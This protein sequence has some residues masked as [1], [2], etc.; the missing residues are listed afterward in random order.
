M[1]RLI[2]LLL[3]AIM[4][5]VVAFAD[6]T[7]CQHDFMSMRN[8]TSH[9][10]ECQKCYEIRN[11]GNH[12]FKDGVCTVCGYEDTEV[13]GEGGHEHIL[14]NGADM[15]YHFEECQV[16][17]ERFNVKDHTFKDDKCTVCGY[18][19]F[20]NPFIDVSENAWF[21]NDVIRAYYDGLINGKTNTTFAP[22][23]N[24]TYV[25]AI[26]LAA[27][28]HQKYT[29][30][31]VTL[32]VGNPWYKP[33]LD[34][35]I[36]NGILKE[37]HGY[38]LNAPATRQGYMRIFAYSLPPEALE[39]I[40]Y[41]A[42]D[43]IPDVKKDPAIYKLYRAGIVGGV[44]AA[45]N[46]NPTANIKRSE[47]AAV[48]TRMMYKAARIEFTLGEKPAETEPLRFKGATSY[49][50][51]GT[52]KFVASVSGGEAPYTYTWYYSDG[53]KGTKLISDSFVTLT[54]DGVGGATAAFIFTENNPYLGKEVKLEVT[55]ANGEKI[56][57]GYTDIPAYFDVEGPAEEEPAETYEKLTITEQPEYIA[58]AKDGDYLTYSVFVKGGKQP[59]KF[60]WLYYTGYK[61]LTDTFKN[62][63][64]AMLSGDV[65]TLKFD[66][67]SPY[68]EKRFFCRV[69]DENGESVSSNVI[70]MPEAPFAME[71]EDIVKNSLG[72]IVVG[73]V[74][75]GKIVPGEH[76]VF[77][78]DDKYTY[79]SG[80]VEAIEMF[81]K[82]L[83]MATAGDRVGLLFKE[84][85]TINTRAA[86]LDYDTQNLIGDK[87]N[88][89]IKEALSVSVSYTPRGNI[90]EW[91]KMS[92]YATG[93]MEPYTYVWQALKDGKSAYNLTSIAKSEEWANG[94]DK[95]T[96]NILLTEQQYAF[97]MSFR[98]MITDA[99]GNIAYSDA[100]IPTPHDLVIANHPQ[101][102]Y[103]NYG[104]S[105]QF[106][107]KALGENG[108]D[109][110][111]KWRYIYDGA[112]TFKDILPTDTWASGYNTD[113]LTIQ[114]EKTELTSH[115][116]YH[117][118]VTDGEGNGA[119]TAA[120]TIFPEKPFIIKQPG[121]VAAKPDTYIE[122]SVEADGRYKPFTYKWY[123]FVNGME[124]F[125]P[126]SQDHE[127]AE[128]ETTN[129]L[130]V[131]VDRKYFDGSFKCYCVITDANGNEVKSLE[132]S[133]TL[134]DNANVSLEP[135]YSSKGDYIVIMP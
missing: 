48:L 96:L 134:S 8:M 92:V 40:N 55:D 36:E 51:F 88:I 127:W 74:K 35:C 43:A 125:Y 13:R 29:E 22:D 111:Y 50:E 122:F 6:D 86:V 110:T 116:Y 56:D 94:F 5:T 17:F 9:Y 26:K 76:L 52:Y 102:V 25:E 24:I 112:K 101:S 91:T 93:G 57:T 130:T 100:Y 118:V 32:T 21:Y 37:D 107:V 41:V 33:Y 38:D 34:Y 62:D 126:V 98:C 42:E 119:I 15:D 58:S 128:G 44:D 69:T 105:V 54:D 71:L 79:G 87:K 83:D 99:A 81:G 133:V 95:D 10:E 108:S 12:V 120:A 63:G 47:V 115:V 121:V 30:G 84:I 7:T 65:I 70:K 45:R 109:V 67:E 4:L 80:K 61:N 39:E 66:L 68:L 28:M 114:V 53:E 31:K 123:Y 27:C 2:T 3:A 72:T 18:D 104:D 106:K 89:A 131:G 49:L 85:G 124:F 20:A 14:M 46:C 117:C 129:T 60:E 78:F 82:Q 132:G 77:T 90:G 16:C 73:R 75:T 103:A 23:L 135:D 19:K 11:A 97:G 59:Y 113:T 64:Y 1:K